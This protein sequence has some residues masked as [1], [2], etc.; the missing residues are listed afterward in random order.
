MTEKEYFHRTVHPDYL[1]EPPD[2]QIHIISR[3]GERWEETSLPW[4]WLQN[5][6]DRQKKIRDL[7]KRLRKFLNANQ[8]EIVETA[9]EAPEIFLELLRTIDFKFER[10]AD[11]GRTLDDKEC[12]AGGLCSYC[13]LHQP[14]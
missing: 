11:C 2:E 10:C 7:F 12:A 1:D 4:E 3:K 13:Y 8:K 9:S 5:Q 6:S 14:E